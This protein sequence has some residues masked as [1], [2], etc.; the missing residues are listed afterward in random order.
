[1]KSGEFRSEKHGKNA[2]K[3][4]L[5]S[6][7]KSLWGE[8]DAL[9]KDDWDSLCIEMGIGR[10]IFSRDEQKQDLA[11]MRV[12]E[13]CDYIRD[14]IVAYRVSE[15][16]AS[17]TP[18]EQPSGEPPLDVKARA[19]YDEKLRRWKEY[20]QGLKSKLKP[21]DNDAFHRWC[22]EACAKKSTE[23][24]A[25]A[26]MARLW[27]LL[28]AFAQDVRQE[29]QVDELRRRMQPRVSGSLSIAWQ[30]PREVFD[31]TAI[32]LEEGPGRLGEVVEITQ[33]DA[34]IIDGDAPPT[35]EPGETS[36]TAG[37]SVSEDSSAASDQRDSAIG[38][39]S[40]EEST[41]GQGPKR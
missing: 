6:H 23:H 33:A 2:T 17:D 37:S 7:I 16:A 31:L 35:S 36:D 4:I 28:S 39:P 11:K 29:V 21:G 41:Q 19:E 32:E 27:V 1:M 25:V 8:L 14:Y 10:K 3:Q 18:P 9:T 24:I 40:A 15:T 20:A 5:F 30:G 22:E 34:S 38:V 13:W 12:T 26:D